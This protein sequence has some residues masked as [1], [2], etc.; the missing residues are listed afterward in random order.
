MV[1]SMYDEYVTSPRYVFINWKWI[2]F[3]IEDLFVKPFY[4]WSF[5]DK[6]NV[7]PWATTPLISTLTFKTK[8]AHNT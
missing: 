7:V 3:I 6:E 5:A 1:S 8:H 4:A 2:E